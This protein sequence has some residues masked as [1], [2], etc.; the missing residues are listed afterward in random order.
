MLAPDLNQRHVFL[1]GP[2]PFMAEVKNALRELGF[3]LVKL[4]SES[5][6]M[7][8]V[9]RGIKGGAKS[10]ILPG[11]R[12]KIRFSKTGLTVDTDET[13]TLLELAEAWGVE[14]DYACRTGD[15]GECEVKFAGRCKVNGLAYA[16]CSV[17]LSDLEVEA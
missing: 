3:D 16:C 8:R 2:E 1:C 14:I 5:F 9:A 4:H 7:G 10:L 11:P 15:C 13:V 6:G 12:H 17:A